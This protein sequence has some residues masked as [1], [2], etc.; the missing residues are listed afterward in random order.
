MPYRLE[1]ALVLATGCVIALIVTP[2]MGRLGVRLNIVATP[3]GRRHHRGVVSRL[4]G[5][6]LALGFFG[7]L[8]FSRFMAIPTADPNETVR[9]WGLIIGGALM[10]IV[11][12]IDDRFE[13]PGHRVS[14]LSVSCRCRHG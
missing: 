5:V 7:A 6:G 13:L 12:L 9:F 14:G 4:G 8:I 3:G 10:F 1:Y 2:L 11:G